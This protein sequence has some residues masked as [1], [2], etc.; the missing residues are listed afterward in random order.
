MSGSLA[1]AQL[2]SWV[3]LLSRSSTSLS[4]HRAPGAGGHSL[5]LSSMPIVSLT[6]LACLGLCSAK[7]PARGKG[8]DDERSKVE[9]KSK[10]VAHP[11]P[12][13]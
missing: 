10:T 2:L 12:L 7:E 11:P 4:F 6:R 9:P 8:L 1:P 3:I 13:S 5:P